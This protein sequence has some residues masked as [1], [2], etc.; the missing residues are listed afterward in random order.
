MRISPMLIAALVGVVAASQAA[1]QG[2]TRG[3]ARPKAAP[4]AA[5]VP[6]DDTVAE[7][8]APPAE[9]EE[10]PAPKA[11]AKKRKAS[12]GK[13][14]VEEYLRDRLT[15]AQKNHHDQKAFGTK[16]SERWDKF[17]NEIFEDRK[18]FET[19]IA[20]QRLNLFETMS[21]VG[22]GYR[23]QAVGDFERMQGTMLKSFEGSQKQK[24]D[25]FFGRLLEDYK[26]YIVEQDRKRAELV[27]SSVEAWKDQRTVTDAAD[28]SEKAEKKKRGKEK[29]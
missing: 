17:F 26:A 6:A 18:R 20:R 12:D 13:G 9:E 27:A 7:D 4:A 28:K 19:S 2:S 21:S 24:M 22:P 29:D 15:V 10:A 16:V 23:D 25:E 14:M 8:E 5:A 1:A 11:K 3:T